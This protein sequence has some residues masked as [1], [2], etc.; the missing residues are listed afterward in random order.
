[1]RTNKQQKTTVRVLRNFTE[2]KRFSME[3]YADQLFG[4]Y[5]VESSPYQFQQFIPQLRRRSQFLNDRNH[6][7]LARYWDYPQQARALAGGSNNGLFHIIDHGYAHLVSRLDPSRTIVTVHDIIP[8][9]WGRGLLS[10]I[11]KARRQWLNEYTLGFLK[12]A[13]HLITDSQNTRD[14]I[15]RHCGCDQRKISIIHLGVSDGFKPLPE[16]DKTTLRR[17]L[18]VPNT[19]TALVMISGE[20]FYKNVRTSY[21]VIERLKILRRK[22]VTL[23]H[24]R[25]AME[26]LEIEPSLKSGVDVVEL[27][28][29]SQQ[30]LVSLYNAVDCLLYPSLYE[31][32]GLPPLEAMACGIPVVASNAASLPEIIGTGGILKD[33]FDVE[34]MAQSLHQLIEDREYRTAQI[35]RGHKQVKQFSWQQCA[36]QTCSVYDKVMT[37]LNSR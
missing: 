13:A 33:P 4:Q 21:Q 28:N 18:G 17:T 1:M 24:V 10:G 2:D 31:G 14:D 29:L 22:P 25:A 37:S 3:V 11:N 8:F 5:S 16:E 7:R 35:A 27:G 30:Q 36:Q 34:G 32:F 9:L 20:A 23:I 12:Q 26:K 19:K 15:I 6:M